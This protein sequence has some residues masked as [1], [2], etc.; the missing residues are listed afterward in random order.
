M[1]GSTK[2]SVPVGAMN[3]STH[4]APGLESS[5]RQ[6]FTFFAVLV[7]CFLSDNLFRLLLYFVLVR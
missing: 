6:W 7:L 2:G 1:V 3:H 5:E 4:S